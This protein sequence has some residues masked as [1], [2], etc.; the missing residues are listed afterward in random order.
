MH[1]DANTY[2]GHTYLLVV[3][4]LNI[5]VLMFVRFSTYW[6]I[7]GFFIN[8]FSGNIDNLVAQ[9][10]SLCNTVRLFLMTLL[11][12][13]WNNTLHPLSQ[14]NAM[15]TSDCFQFGTICS[16]FVFGGNTLFINLHVY[17]VYNGCSL[18]CVLRSWFLLTILSVHGLFG[19]KNVSVQPVSSYA[20]L[21]CR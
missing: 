6:R 10:C 13:V 20:L 4:H 21:S 15:A 1:I 3:W 14:N 11:F 2:W 17:V 12:S 5:Y 7:V 19:V 18:G 8:R 16:S 9:S